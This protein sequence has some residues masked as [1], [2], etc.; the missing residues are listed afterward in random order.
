MNNSAF[1][2]LWRNS[3][4][5]NVPLQ[6]SNSSQKKGTFSAARKVC[7]IFQR[8]KSDLEPRGWNR[9]KVKTPSFWLRKLRKKKERGKKKSIGWP[10]DSFKSFLSG[11]KRYCERSKIKWK[12]LLYNEPSYNRP[13]Y[14]HR[15]ISLR[16]NVRMD[17]HIISSDFRKGESQ[18]A[19]SIESIIHNTVEIFI[20][21]IEQL[22]WIS[23]ESLLEYPCKYANTFMKEDDLQEGFQQIPWHKFRIR[24]KCKI[25]RILNVFV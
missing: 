12:T 11:N 20:M 14:P 13:C 16:R 8:L 2:F 10:R 5:K 3:R 23:L 18:W 9:F 1:L 17:F 22:L 15:W 7:Y 24:I 4:A 21:K 25:F 6:A 19:I